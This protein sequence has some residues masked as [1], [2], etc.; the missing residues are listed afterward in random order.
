M[1]ENL[2]MDIVCF[3]HLRWNFVYQRPQHLLSRFAAGHR[4]YFVEE[5]VFDATENHVRIHRPGNTALWII[6]PHLIPGTEEEIIKAQ[7]LLTY[8]WMDRV[9]IDKYLCW[10]YSPLA[11]QFTEHLQPELIVYDCMD[12]LS[13]FRN[14]SGK[15]R[16]TEMLLLDKADIVFTG[17]NSLYEAK[18]SLHNNI[19]CFPSSIDKEHFGSARKSLPEPKDQ[20]NITHP[21]IG[22]YGVIDERFNMSLVESLSKQKPNWQFIILGPTA[23]ID[24]TQLPAAVNIHYLGF[25][26]YDEL[27]YYLS[28]WDVAMMPFALNESTKFISPTKTPEYLAGGKPVVSTSI[29]DVVDPYGKKGLVHIA[30]TVN[31]F[32]KAIDM[33]VLDRDD[34]TW[35]EKVD[36]FLQG[37]SWDSTFEK[38]MQLIVSTHEQKKESFNSKR[39]AY[40]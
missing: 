13:A 2:E 34:K 38:M 40:V 4:V 5:P 3:S 12:E 28:G 19:Y 18:K 37:N 29:R 27:P 17:G 24:P 15:I 31:D 1:N 16:P 33:A 35:M 25:K 32:D 8:E 26:T 6:T 9:K 7:Q 36:A 21:R 14:A 11:L 39:Q 23:K 30:D 22:Y 20:V 10:Y